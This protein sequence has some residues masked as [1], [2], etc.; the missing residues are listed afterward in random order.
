MGGGAI[1]FGVGYYLK[2]IIVVDNQI[3]VHSFRSYSIFVGMPGIP[4]M[5]IG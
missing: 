4:K 3:R 2:K 5:G 1:G